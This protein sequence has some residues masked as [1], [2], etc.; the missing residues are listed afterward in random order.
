MEGNSMASIFFNGTFGSDDPTRATL[1]FLSASGAIEAGHEPSVGL[2][3]EAVYLMKDYVA[4]Q[5]DGVAWPPLVEIIQ[6]VIEHEV[7]IYV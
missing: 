6:K 4:E 7:P 5:I 3:G 2:V 1:P